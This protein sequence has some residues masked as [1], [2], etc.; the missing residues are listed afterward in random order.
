MKFYNISNSTKRDLLLFFLILL[1]A[2]VRI[3]TVG[4]PELS[5]LANFTPLGA[6]ALFGGAYFSGV[7]AYLIPLGTIFLSDLLLNLL[8]FDS[9]YPLIYDGMLWVYLAFSLMILVGRWLSNNLRIR[10][11]ILSTLVITFIHW[12]VTDIGVWLT[13][14]LYPMTLKGLWTCL[15]AAIPFEKNFL[16]GT[17]VYG[18][19][20]F[21]IF[22]WLLF[23]NPSLVRR[24]IVN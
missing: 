1:I 23:T 17:L 21:G 5:S 20:L 14:T 8:F 18:I 6:I 12:V 4:N 16:I 15:L 9:G 24:R 10:N 7:R 13:G 3:L 11:L 22:E 19:L 2:C